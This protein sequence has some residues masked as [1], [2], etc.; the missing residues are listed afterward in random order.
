MSPRPVP[1]GGRRSPA[2]E[3][4]N[5]ASHH[6]VQPGMLR[7]SLPCLFFTQHA[8]C[9]TLTASYPVYCFPQKGG[10]VR[11]GPSV[12]LRTITWVPGPPPAEGS[13]TGVWLPDSVPPTQAPSPLSEKQGSA[14]TMLGCGPTRGWQWC[15]EEYT[16]RRGSLSTSELLTYSPHMPVSCLAWAL[17]PHPHAG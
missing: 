5:Q 1:H 11:K 13:L 17:D 8:H 3:A 16:V 4:P 6:S 10:F 14:V 12:S 7:P 9:L 2:P 15:R